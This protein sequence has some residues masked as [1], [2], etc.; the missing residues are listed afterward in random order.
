M[1]KLNYQKKES[2]NLPINPQYPII[3]VPTN[4][5]PALIATNLT[6]QYAELQKKEEIRKK[7]EEIA[8]QPNKFQRKDFAVQKKKVRV[9]PVIDR[10]KV[11]DECVKLER[12][13]Q[14]LEKEIQDLQKG[15]QKSDDVK[16]KEIKEIKELSQMI[17]R[18]KEA[19]QEGIIELHKLVS[20][21]YPD[22]SLNQVVDMLKIDPHVVGY[23]PV[24]QDFTS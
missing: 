5:E 24:D 1:K 16:Q 22:M 4:I 9:A 19:S 7:R 8:K 10:S 21:Q 12:G 18:W 14:Q 23:N 2:Q 15:D 20:Q 13:I 17:Q 6:E 3:I 11:I